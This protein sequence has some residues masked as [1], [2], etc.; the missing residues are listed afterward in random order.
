MPFSTTYATTPH[1]LFFRNMVAKPGFAEA[2]QNVP[3]NSR[4]A[5][6]EA[7]M[8]PYYPQAATCPLATLAARGA[9]ACLQT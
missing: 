6:A 8:G 2:V 1:V 5:S 7:V 9:S 4:P 3:E